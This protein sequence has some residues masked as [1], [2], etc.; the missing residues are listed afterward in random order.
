[1][2]SEISYVSWGNV[3]LGEFEE[4]ESHKKGELA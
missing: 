3:S 4:D 1:M 2:L